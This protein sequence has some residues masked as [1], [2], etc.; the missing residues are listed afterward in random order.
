[1]HGPQHTAELT[2]DSL[3]I[4]LQELDHAGPDGSQ[5]DQPELHLSH[6]HAYPTLAFLIWGTAI[7]PNALRMPRTAWRV[8]CSFSM[9]AKRTN[10][11]P[12]G[13]NPTPGDTETLASVRRNFANSIAPILRNGSGISAHTNIVPFGLG[14]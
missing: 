7:S 10:P 5:P 2:S 13:P 8:R 1:M 12:Y 3:I 9:R 4:V 14:M 6:S 11:S